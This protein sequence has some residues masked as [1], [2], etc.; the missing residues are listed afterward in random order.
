MDKSW[1]GLPPVTMSTGGTTVPFSMVMS[2]SWAISGNRRA[3]T[4]RG[5]GSI[6]LAHTGVIPTRW[7]AK[8]NPPMPSKRLPRVIMGTSPSPAIRVSPW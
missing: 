2:P 3:V 1:Q 5:N 4:R 8:G 6:S 7:A